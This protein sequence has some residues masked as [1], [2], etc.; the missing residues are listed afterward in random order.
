M[1]NQYAYGEES[2]VAL[3]NFLKE[4]YPAHRPSHVLLAGRALAIYSTAR[5]AGVT[6]FY[7][8]RPSV[9]PFQSLVPVAGY[10]FSDNEYVIDLDSQNPDVPAIAIGRIPAKMLR[11]SKSI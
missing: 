3:S 1:Y 4:Y 2:P 7:R 11:N 6:Y 10:P 5:E 8:N 9:F